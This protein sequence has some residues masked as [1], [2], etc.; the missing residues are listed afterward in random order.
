MQENDLDFVPVEAAGLA[1]SIDSTPFSFEAADTIHC[2]LHAAGFNQIVI[3]AH[4]ADVSSGGIEA[5]LKVVTR[6]GAL[7][8][9]LR[10][11]PT[12]LSEAEPLVRAAL[13]ARERNGKVSLGA[14]TW[15]VTATAD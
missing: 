2:I 4:D 10:E 14:A 13:S 8:K 5:M 12:L 3:T 6:V 11:N 1:T 15:I 7:G 9:V